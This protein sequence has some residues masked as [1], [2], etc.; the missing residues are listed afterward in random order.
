MDP[1]GDLYRS[2][3]VVKLT[4]VAE[5]GWSFLGWKGDLAGGDVITELRINSEKAVGAVFGT[6]LSVRV[7][8][9]G[10]VARVPEAALYAFGSVVQLVAAPATNRYLDHWVIDGLIRKPDN[11]LDPTVTNALMTIEAHFH[12][13]GPTQGMLYS[14][15]EGMGTIRVDPEQGVYT[16]GQM[17]VVTAIPAQGQVLTGWSGDASGDENPLPFTIH[18]INRVVARFRPERFIPS[19]RLF[20]SKGLEL[21]FVGE[22]GAPYRLEAATDLTQ[23][24]VLVTVTNTAPL[25]EVLDPTATNLSWRFYRIRRAE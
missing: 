4:A 11:P 20:A 21:T 22:V 14:G 16:N 9:E 19:A 7:V 18:G 6:P 10:N 24:T 23:W 13:P 8:G 15:V 17:V 5:A 1:P 3:A 12:L 25:M 2:N